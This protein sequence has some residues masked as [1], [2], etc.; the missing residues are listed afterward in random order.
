MC[1]RSAWTAPIAPVAACSDASLQV[2]GFCWNNAIV[3]P[4][5]L[6]L[7]PPG[8]SSILNQSVCTHTHTHTAAA[9]SPLTRYSQPPLLPARLVWLAK[10]AP[11]ATP[12]AVPSGTIVK[13]GVC[14]CVFVWHSCCSNC[15]THPAALL[16]DPGT[17]QQDS[18]AL[19]GSHTRSDQQHGPSSSRV[20]AS[21]ECLEWPINCCP[22]ALGWGAV[23]LAQADRCADTAATS[24]DWHDAVAG[25][26]AAGAFL[27]PSHC[28]AVD[29]CSQ[30]QQWVTMPVL[31]ICPDRFSVC[32]RARS[33][34][35]LWL[36]QQVS[37]AS[38]RLVSAYILLPQE[39]HSARQA[40]A[41]LMVCSLLLDCP[42]SIPGGGS[43][44]LGSSTGVSHAERRVRWR[45]RGEQA[46]QDAV[47]GALKPQPNRQHRQ[48]ATCA[49]QQQLGS[50]GRPW[51]YGSPLARRAK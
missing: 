34:R 42:C 48:L 13:V 6:L 27:P 19:R 23:A 40:G 20:R 7:H 50:A 9:R 11:P 39:H 44:P 28:T 18:Q 5:E 4:P 36:L 17:G 30:Q 24:C 38:W 10:I 3:R 16:L 25:A 21:G 37:R 33:R 8:C 49:Q 45:R 32:C 12:S 22:I 51:C 14:W 35:R 29:Q 2:G 43:W 47:P 46:A 26:R 31:V 1:V 15:P 41:N